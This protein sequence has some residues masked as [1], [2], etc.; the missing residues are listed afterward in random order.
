MLQLPPSPV[1]SQLLKVKLKVTPEAP[2]TA[3][4][5]LHY[6]LR[7]KCWTDRE[8][9]YLNYGLHTVTKGTILRAL[10]WKLSDGIFG[11]FSNEL[12]QS[13]S[14][15]ALLS[16]RHIALYLEDALSVTYVQ[17]SQHGRRLNK[18]TF[19]FCLL[20][21]LHT[22]WWCF[23]MDTA[24]VLLL[25]NEWMNLVLCCSLTWKAAKDYFHYQIIWWWFSWRIV[26]FLPA[27]C[28]TLSIW[29]FAVFFF[30]LYE[31]NIF[32]FWNISK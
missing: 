28:S 25:L 13:K 21:S 18:L 10:W 17:I 15:A 32:E 3:P 4:P 29:R 19:I 5:T 27:A 6:R 14:C 30:V 11:C 26:L 22:N 2:I 20:W 24:E 7:W 9:R 1:V 31:L 12:V 16:E 8:F 23:L